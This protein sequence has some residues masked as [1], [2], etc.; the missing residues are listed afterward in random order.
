ML[1]DIKKILYCTDLS[2]NSA[3]AFRYAV[4]LGK[5]TGAELH[6]LHVVE[7]LSEDAMLTLRT[8]IIDRTQR[9]DALEERR[10][11]ARTLLD[12]RQDAFWAGVDEEDRKVR[13]Q[14]KS[15]EVVESYPAEAILRQAEAKKCDLIVMG[16]HEKG[17][18]H[19]FLGSVAK[20]VLHR[21]RAPTM[22]IPLPRKE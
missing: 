4:L 1:P 6:L 7:K 3:Q 13:D 8:Y 17:L 2:E 11:L 15:I 5:M 9:H 10:K 20:D 21:S 12:K 19:A 14:I 16:T 18:S 22:I